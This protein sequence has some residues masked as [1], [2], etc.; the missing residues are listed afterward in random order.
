MQLDAYK[1]CQINWDLTPEEAVTLYLEWGNNNWHGKHPPVRSKHDVA[2]Y[3]VVDT[4]GEKP[5]VR[6]VRRN[7]EEAV[8]LAALPLPENLAG[9]FRHET[10]SRKGIYHPT[11][12][13]KDWLKGQMHH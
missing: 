4:W 6:L 2:H 8:D 12:P 9:E 5:T 7:S 1:N 10:G 11:E 13:I 3:F